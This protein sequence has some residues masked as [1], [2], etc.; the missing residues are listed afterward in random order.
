MCEYLSVGKILPESAMKEKSLDNYEYID[1]IKTGRSGS[2]VFIARKHRQTQ[3]V[4]IK[5]DTPKV[6][7]PEIVFNCYTDTLHDAKRIF[8]DVIDFGIIAESHNKFGKKGRAFIVT[9]YINGITLEE[10]LQQELPPHKHSLSIVFQMAF[11]LMQLWRRHGVRHC[12]LHARNIIV[13]ASDPYTKKNGLFSFE[14]TKYQ[15]KFDLSGCPK[16][17]IIDM[18]L[19][20]RKVDPTKR[21]FATYILRL[22]QIY[23]NPSDLTKVR[24][25]IKSRQSLSTELIE[26][27]KTNTKN[28][29]NNHRSDLEAIIGIEDVL[30]KLYGLDA[31]QPPS[32]RIPKRRTK[33]LTYYSILSSKRFDSLRA[34]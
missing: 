9:E 5:V 7:M 17:R 13:D 8:P 25:K 10:F 18:G 14:G 23:M 32:S 3:K 2:L 29:C 22:Y 11:A 33:S 16:V 30:V 6:L 12:D 21:S 34:A 31:E 15:H 26:F 1:S 19:C 4:I 20:Q 24:L 28:T 27:M